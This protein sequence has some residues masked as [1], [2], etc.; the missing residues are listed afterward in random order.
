M[1]AIHAIRGSILCGEAAAIGRASKFS[2]RRFYYVTTR[3]NSLIFFL[4]C[5]ESQDKILRN[6][7]GSDVVV[8]PRYYPQDWPIRTRMHIRTVKR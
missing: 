4:K 2:D 8:D 5:V 3:R 6:T 7:L 1:K